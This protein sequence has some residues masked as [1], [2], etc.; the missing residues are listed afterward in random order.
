MQEI[1]DRIAAEIGVAPDV[2]HKATSMIVAFI[3]AE[4]PA[5][6]VDVIRQNVPGFDEL[7][8]TGAAHTEAADAAS[9]A[10]GGGLMGALGG[11]MGG[12]G[13]GLMGA[14]GGLMGGSQGGGLAGALSLLGRLQQDGLDIDQVKTMA[15]GLLGELRQ[16]AGEENVAKLVS[17]I[18][19]AER[20]LG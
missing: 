2:A 3:V 17:G 20:L 1:I 13:G 9:G 19:G 15:G 7:A 6:Y 10:A 11:L 12:G 14:L 5:Q 4:A 18:P 16:V 8:A